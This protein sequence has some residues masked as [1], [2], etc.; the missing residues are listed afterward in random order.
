MTKVITINGQRFVLPDN[1]N[2]KEI[3]ALAGFLLTL[4]PVDYEY[5]IDTGRSVYFASDRSAEVRLESLQLV[6]KA[7]AEAQGKVSR[8][9]YDAKKAEKAS[10]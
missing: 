3:Q 5:L 7:E 2:T 8:E 4:T 6:T 9:A 10:A 1:M